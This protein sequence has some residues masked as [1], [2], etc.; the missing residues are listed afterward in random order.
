M[1]R[2]LTVTLIAFVFI[3]AGISGIVYHAPEWKEIGLHRETIWAFVVRLT[4]ILA[5]I[6]LLK[7]SN[8]ARWVLVG[9]MVYHVVLSF[10]HSTAELV[11]HIAVTIVVVIALFNPKTNLFFNRRI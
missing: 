2:P 8:I 11:M 4:A 7:A 3:I 9:W 1:K 10:Y 6:F 5:G